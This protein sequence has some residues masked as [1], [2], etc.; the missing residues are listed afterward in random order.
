MRGFE[1]T[2]RDAEQ[3]EMYSKVR[4]LSMNIT[5][6]RVRDKKQHNRPFYVEEF[7]GGMDLDELREPSVT[8]VLATMDTLEPASR[9]WIIALYVYLPPFLNEQGFLRGTY[10]VLKWPH[11]PRTKGLSNQV[12]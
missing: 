3:A 9:N 1:V 4:E 10:K 12:A 8:M 2:E 5:I 11:Y 6:L 7:I